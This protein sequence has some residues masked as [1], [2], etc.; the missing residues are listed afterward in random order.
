MAERGLLCLTKDAPLTFVTQE[1][2][3]VLKALCQE[4][5]PN[6]YIFLVSQYH[7]QI[8]VPV[9]YVTQALAFWGH[10]ISVVF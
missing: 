7:H 8:Q 4:P 1:I 6:I 2:P 3:R 9:L 10:L 5:R